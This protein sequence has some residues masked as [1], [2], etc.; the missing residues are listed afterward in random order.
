VKQK[1]ENRKQIRLP[2]LVIVVPCFNESEV[3]PICLDSLKKVVEQ[4]IAQH[5]I[6]SNSYILFSDDCSQDDTWSQITMATQKSLHVK[7]IRLSRNK[8]HQLNLIAGLTCAH[9]DADITI[10]IDADLQD[11]I[12]VIAQMVDAYIEGNEIVYGVRNSRESDN[13]FKR[14]TA[15]SFYKFMS[16]MGVDQVSNHAD[17]RLL[18]KKALAALL[19]YQEQNLYIRGL[20]PLIGF[21]STHIYYKRMP[22]MEGESKYPLRKMIS[23]ALTGITSLTVTPLRIITVI[24]FLACLFSIIIFTYVVILK[25]MGQTV[26]G[27]SSMIAAIILCSGVQMLSLGI[28]GEYIG[29][30]YIEVKNRPKFFIENIAGFSNTFND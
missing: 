21:N 2:V 22:R 5:K 17:F 14:S 20:I 11:D 24:G 9:K 18:G 28:I 29:K 19:Q 7:G 1:T 27:W 26:A 3:F 16:V 25:L 30:I 8:G 10:S 4:L 13:Y 12:S 6:S 15:Q 23:L